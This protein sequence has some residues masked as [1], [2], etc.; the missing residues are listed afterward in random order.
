MILLLETRLKNIVGNLTDFSITR[1]YYQ[2]WAIILLQK[3]EYR[4]EKKRMTKNQFKTDGSMTWEYDLKT[5]M[6]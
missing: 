3:Q 2:T 6:I 4:L 1:I 5:H